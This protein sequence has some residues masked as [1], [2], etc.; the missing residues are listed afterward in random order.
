E[1]YQGV[2]NPEEKKIQLFAEEMFRTTFKP[3]VERR[4]MAKLGYLLGPNGMPIDQ[5]GQQ[6]DPRQVLAGNGWQ[7]AMQ[8]QGQP[9]QQ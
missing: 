3:L 8:P 5:T 4:M 2:A 6:A 9:Q 7:P 1:D